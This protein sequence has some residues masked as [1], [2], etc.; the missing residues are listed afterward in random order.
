MFLAYF[1]QYNSFPTS[2]PDHYQISREFTRLN[3]LHILYNIQIETEEMTWEPTHIQTA[4]LTSGFTRL[5]WFIADADLA[6]GSLHRVEVG[7]V[8][9]VSDSHAASN[10]KVKVYKVSEYSY[11]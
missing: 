5:R 10:F 9:D 2:L 11:I 6:F 8:A 3:F 7:S 4:S 1:N